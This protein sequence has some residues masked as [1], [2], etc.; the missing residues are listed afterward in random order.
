M[1]AAQ[2]S[3]NP[4]FV[5]QDA[6]TRAHLK[7][8]SHLAVGLVMS[9]RDNGDGRGFYASVPH[10]ANESGIGPDTVE[11][12]IARLRRD[13]WLKQVRKGGSNGSSTWASRYQLTI[14]PPATVEEEARTSA[15]HQSGPEGTKTRPIG[16][17]PGQQPTVTGTDAG[18]VDEFSPFTPDD[19]GAAVFAPRIYSPSEDEI[20][21]VDEAE[22]DRPT[23]L[24]PRLDPSTGSQAAAYRAHERTWRDEGYSEDDPSLSPPDETATHNTSLGRRN[25]DR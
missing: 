1:S 19:S 3:R 9:L 10:L 18:R 14:P 6:L 11:R 5:W 17:R 23:T 8:P 13:G 16:T 2:D 4:K 21:S 20:N 22:A 12:A 7:P 15:D 24:R 25:G